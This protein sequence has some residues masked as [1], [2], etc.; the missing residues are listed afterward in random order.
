MR[1]VWSIALLSLALV[2]CSQVQH[3]GSSGYAPVVTL[4]YGAVYWLDELH[5]TRLM[6]PG[7]VKLTVA[8]WEQALLDD[9]GDGNRIRLAL[10]LIAGDLSVRD[11][12]R[13]RE[14][15]D[16]LTAAPAGTNDRELVFIM[17]QILEQQEQQ[18]Q[19]S[20][21]IDKLNTQARQ[22][23]RRIRELEQQQRAL[24]DIEQNIQQRTVQPDTDNE[25][26]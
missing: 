15:L 14:L 10:L 22:R 11:P 8:K 2:A 26:E 18:E 7:E 6:A 13:A 16:E 19:A 4:G 20:A 17:R 24:T 25:G 23:N 21:E 5:S 12:K 3:H 1:S 9:P